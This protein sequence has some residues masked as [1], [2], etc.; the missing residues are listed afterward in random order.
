MYMFIDIDIDIDRYI[1]IYLYIIYI[2]YL[3]ICL[4]RVLRTTVNHYK[5]LYYIGLYHITTG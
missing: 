1:Y 2:L 5:S 4:N 3:Y